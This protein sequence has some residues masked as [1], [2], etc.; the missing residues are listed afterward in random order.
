MDVTI[1]E[2]IID[3]EPETFPMRNTNSHLPVENLYRHSEI[4][5]GRRNINTMFFPEN[6]ARCVIGG[7]KQARE[8]ECGGSARLLRS[9]ST[10]SILI[11]VYDEYSNT[12][13]KVYETSETNS[14]VQIS[15]S[16]HLNCQIML[17]TWSRPPFNCVVLFCEMWRV[18][19]A[20]RSIWFYV[21][22]I[23]ELRKSKRVLQTLAFER[24]GRVYCTQLFMCERH[25]GYIGRGTLPF[26]TLSL[27]QLQYIGSIQYSSTLASLF[28]GFSCLPPAFFLPLIPQLPTKPIALLPPP[29]NLSS[30]RTIDKHFHGSLAPPHFSTSSLNLSPLTRLIAPSSWPEAK[31]CCQTRFASTRSKR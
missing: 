24:S 26:R 2:S 29:S 6:C 27:I 14:Q 22:S 20:A 10:D 4:W 9:R 12:V 16:K 21:E 18:A 3:P 8:E 31:T 17:V 30:L 19:I 11:K 23:T 15:N 7:R 13:Y 5:A 25:S 1:S 28:Y